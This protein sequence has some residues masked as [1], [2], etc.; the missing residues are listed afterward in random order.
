MKRIILSITSFHEGETDS[1]TKL[2][3][4]ILEVQKEY[5]CLIG[6]EEVKE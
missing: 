5:S 6:F 3:K 2:K 1:L 4:L